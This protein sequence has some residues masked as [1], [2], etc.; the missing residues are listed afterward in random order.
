M[1]LCSRSE[2]NAPFGTVDVVQQ[3]VLSIHFDVSLV[4]IGLGIAKIQP[5]EPRASSNQ[6]QACGIEKTPELLV[7]F[8][9]SDRVRQLLRMTV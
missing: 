2:S 1:P 3:P 4:Q 8:D 6:G 5:D 9:T 7:I